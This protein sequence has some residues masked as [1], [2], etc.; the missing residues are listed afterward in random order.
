MSLPFCNEQSKR[1][2][3]MFIDLS[4]N[5][6]LFTNSL[7]FASNKTKIRQ[8]K[9][10]PSATSPKTHKKPDKTKQTPSGKQVFTAVF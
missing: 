6:T 5:I 7:G 1:D 3:A 8:A 4:R 10:Q 9:R 2:I